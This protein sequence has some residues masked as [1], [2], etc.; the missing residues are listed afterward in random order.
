MMNQA[1]REQLADDMSAQAIES[2]LLAGRRIRYGSM[3]HQVLDAEDV[4]TEITKPEFEA[5]CRAFD[6]GDAFE[7]KRLLDA[8]R[9]R[10]CAALAQR[11]AGL[12]SEYLAHLDEQECA[13]DRHSM[14]EAG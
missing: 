10:A 6:A 14:R 1:S 3:R 12:R 9:A 7:A 8:A 13:A 11:H 4:K 5:V 2:A